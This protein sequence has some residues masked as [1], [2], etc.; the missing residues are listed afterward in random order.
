MVV[1]ALMMVTLPVMSSCGSHHAPPRCDEG[2]PCT[3]PSL[4][5]CGA[6]ASVS[7][8]QALAAADGQLTVRGR[9]ELGNVLCELSCGCHGG[10]SLVD[11][12]A[13]D[14]IRVRGDGIGC[15]GPREHLCCSPD[16]IGKQV[17][18][19]GTLR[20]DNLGVWLEDATLCAAQ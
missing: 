4:A 11:P 19:R 17:I 9:V 20:H 6:E 15:T 7:V 14:R 10:L 2:T 13:N 3:P 1:V 5:S 8:V 18:A 16:A 12:D